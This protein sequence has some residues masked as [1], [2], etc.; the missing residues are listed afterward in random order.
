M[1]LK[2]GFDGKLYLA[3]ITEG[4]YTLGEEIDIVKDCD[5][6]ESRDEIEANDRS[7]KGRKRYLAGLMDGKL[8][9]GVNTNPEN[10]N[11][12]LVRAAFLSGEPI[13]LG[14]LFQD[15][16]ITEDNEGTVGTFVITG[17]KKGQPLNGAQ[18]TDVSASM[19][20][21]AG[22]FPPTGGASPS[23]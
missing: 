9:F 10:E 5:L 8:S 19:Q 3:T 13:G 18:T 1:S 4:G 23:A 6:D 17:W 7:N 21:F 16:S 12:K 20:T 11:F 22:D 15:K 14:V 2:T